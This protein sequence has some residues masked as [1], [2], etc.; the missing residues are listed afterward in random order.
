MS[1]FR[2]LDLPAELRNEVYKLAPGAGHR[3][4]SEYKLSWRQLRVL[5]P[6]LDKYAK[7]LF[8]RS[9]GASVSLMW[10][11]LATLVSSWTDFQTTFRTAEKYPGWN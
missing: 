9:S 3:T 10:T 4:S 6:A 8:Q 1:S 7:R 11:L 2:L 5:E